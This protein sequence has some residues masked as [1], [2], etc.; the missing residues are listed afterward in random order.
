M[1]PVIAPLPMAGLAFTSWNGM[2]PAAAGATASCVPVIFE[3]S[4]AAQVAGGP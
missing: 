2:L 1:T 4:L 3:P